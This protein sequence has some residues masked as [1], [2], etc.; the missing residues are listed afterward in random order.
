[1]ALPVAAPLAAA[2]VGTVGSDTAPTQVG[3]TAAGRGHEVSASA[4]AVPGSSTLSRPAVVPDR[5]VPADARQ[6]SGVDPVGMPSPP[7]QPAPPAPA[8]A[9]PAPA[10]QRT[11]FVAGQSQELPG[12]RTRFA[13]VFANPDGTRTAKYGTRPV[14][15][16]A[17]DGSWRPIDTN[18]VGNGVGRLVKGADAGATSFA[19]SAADPQIA[20]LDVGSGR[21]VGFGLSKARPAPGRVSGDT[22]TYP[23]VAAATSLVLQ[24]LADGG[25]KESLVLASPAAPRSWDFPL[26]LTGLTP[27]LS[28]A[29]TVELVDAAGTVA[30]EIPHG[31]MEDSA[32][33]PSGDGAES[34]AVTFALNQTAA[35]WVLTVTADS[36]WLD[37][38]AR[39]YPVTVDPT[40][41]WN[42]GAESD[43]YAQTGYTTAHYTETEVKTGTYDGGSNK[44]ATYLAFPT[45]TTDLS[46]AT[47]Y[48]VD[49]NLFDIWSWSCGSDR[50]YTIHQVTA[51]WSNSSVTAFPGPA[52]SATALGPV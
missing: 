40:V 6:P 10:P 44:A 49:L 23:G 52:F 33:S 20:L 24:A 7:A 30:A 41:F 13:T 12:E 45:V 46:H 2:P 31:F 26:S 16:Q 39:V 36:A 50:S 5:A 35:G 32:W 37:D 29:G 8:P 3:G 11:G 1:V 42:Y 15:F 38:P 25:V 51:P 21:R 48:D 19:A 43:T 17:A 22:V 4:T 9:A 34:E 14:N 28:A 18:L 47:I 27:R